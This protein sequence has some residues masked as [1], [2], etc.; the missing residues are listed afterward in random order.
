MMTLFAWRWP[1]QGR[2]VDAERQLQE[3]RDENA[4]RAP[5]SPRSPRRRPLSACS[6]RAP[7][8]NLLVC[9]FRSGYAQVAVP[10]RVEAI[11]RSRRLG[12][13]AVAKE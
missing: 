2:A 10:L 4:V 12:R 13:P 6:R 3:L 7:A 8:L 11:T 9:A 1:A 5:R